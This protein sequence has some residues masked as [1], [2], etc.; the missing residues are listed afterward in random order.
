MIGLGE[1]LRILRT[2]SPGEEQRGPA[3]LRAELRH[4]RLCTCGTT[5]A[6]CPIWGL[7]LDWLPVHDHF[8]VAD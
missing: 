7:L 8:P 2:P 1:A 5:A 3:R 4:Q 6:S